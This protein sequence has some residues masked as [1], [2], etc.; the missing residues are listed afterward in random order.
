MGMLYY[1]KDARC[2]WYWAKGMVAADGC[3]R[4]HTEQGDMYVLRDEMPWNVVG[5]KSFGILNKGARAT[6]DAMDRVAA[7]KKEQADLADPQAA[8]SFSFLFRRTPYVHQATA[9]EYMMHYPKLLMVLE[10]GLGKTFITYM[11]VRIWKERG[12]PHRTLVVCPRI[13]LQNWLRE[14]EQYTDMRI[15]PYYGNPAQRE[16]CRS[17]LQAEPWDMVATTFDM[18]V[19]RRETPLQVYESM[20][21]K[22]PATMREKYVERWRESGTVSDDVAAALLC[23]MSVRQKAKAAARVLSGIPAIR[24]PAG[25]LREARQ[26][27]NSADFLYGLPW[28]NL[29]VDEASR[30]LNIKSQRS[31]SVE[32]MAGKAKRA[33]MLSG[34]LCVGRPTDVYM[35][36]KI[37]DPAIIPM[38]WTTFRDKFCIFRD[39]KKHIVDGY[40][41]LEKLKMFVDPHM[42]TMVRSDC[43][44]MPE[45]VFVKRYYEVSDEQ[46][47][48]Y[49]AI[50]VEDWISTG[51]GE[52]IASEL[53]V[54]K[55]TK[56]MQVLSGFV[57]TQ[58][59]CTAVC[60]DCP[61]IPYCLCNDINPGTLRC[62]NSNAV[63][64]KEYRVISLGNGK[65]K[66]LEEDLD[67]L[68]DDEK[69]K[70]IVWAWYRYDLAAIAA[71]LKR[72]KIGFVMAGEPECDTRFNA[73]SKIRVFLGQTRQGIGITLNAASVTIYYS[74]GPD[75]EARLQSMDRNYRIGQKNSVI[76]HDY[77]CDGSVEETMLEMLEHKEDVKNFMQTDMECLSCKQRLLCKNVGHYTKEC[78]HAMEIAMAETRLMLRIPLIGT[79]FEDYAGIER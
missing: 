72:K 74:H 8:N 63:K 77:V 7:I 75:L 41:N 67:D 73:D 21:Q 49:N 79:T 44:D 13:V 11:S 50:A 58:C 39:A 5:L 43:I 2:F 48:Y 46:Q 45:R 4:R 68:L 34:T 6:G 32:R 23:D 66:L 22:M 51:N 26:E 55:L 3:Y 17:R 12:I 47:E 1:S 19:Q 57:K 35:P 38:N 37:L 33:Y 9:I 25:L 61:H 31:H 30:C 10:Q 14:V 71:L 62:R 69:Q 60:G 54:Q 40:K 27:A 65:L 15:L 29:V 59:N 52:G 76:V 28:D 64:Q 70:V 24:M 53:M 36:A 56:C 16:A 20:W 42:L 18:L 78:P